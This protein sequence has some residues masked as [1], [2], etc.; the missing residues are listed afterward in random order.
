MSADIHM[1]THTNRLVK[2][3]ADN[4]LTGCIHCMF[5]FVLHME[6]Y[7]AGGNISVYTLCVNI[8]IYRCEL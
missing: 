2:I 1:H 3:N 6:M 5:L 7:S 4:L 8:F